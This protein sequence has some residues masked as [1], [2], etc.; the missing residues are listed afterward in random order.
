MSALLLRHLL[1][2]VLAMLWITSVSALTPSLSLAAN[3]V[4]AAGSSV[5]ISVVWAAGS[6]FPAKG[7]LEILLE[8]AGI[9]LVN[10][11]IPSVAE[12]KAYAATLPKTLEPGASTLRLCA[13]GT[14]TCVES[15]P[16]TIGAASSGTTA[17]AA[18]TT[19]KHQS[20]TGRASGSAAPAA[21]STLGSAPSTGSNDFG[22]LSTP[23]IAGIAGGAAAFL[24]LVVIGCWYSRPKPSRTS[25]SFSHNELEKGFHSKDHS[26]WACQR[27]SRLF[28]SK[29]ATQEDL[30]FPYTTMVSD[31]SNSH[32]SQSQSTATV[33]FNDCDRPSHDAGLSRP[34]QDAFQA[35]PAPGMSPARTSSTKADLELSLPPVLTDARTVLFSR[36]SEQLDELAVV[37]SQKVFVLKVFSDNWAFIQTQA[38]ERGLVPMTYLSGKTVSPARSSNIPGSSSSSVVSTAVDTWGSPR[39]SNSAANLIK[40]SEAPRDGDSDQES[41]ASQGGDLDI[42]VAPVPEYLNAAFQY[43]ATR[44][45]ELS[46]GLGERIRVL[47]RFRDG[48]GLGQNSQGHIGLIPLNFL[49]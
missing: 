5:S 26:G 24:A 18:S 36:E 15:T 30:Q 8:P 3:T 40:A 46:L 21:L 43:T 23:V 4:W 19:L 44:A 34:S 12:T 6:T 49:R 29:R 7:R 2:T 14:T 32:S 9:L 17:A 11:S 1:R 48:W 47:K 25:M 31:Q 13:I 39:S 37:P 10:K 41:S 38:G 42:T 27:S 33:T 22:G 28:F 35:G 20:A 45:D 16:L